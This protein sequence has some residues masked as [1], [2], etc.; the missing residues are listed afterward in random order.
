MPLPGAGLLVGWSRVFADLTPSAS[1][2]SEVSKNSK[3]SN[4]PTTQ[5]QNQK[6][7]S[8]SK[9]KSRSKSKP[10][11]GARAAKVRVKQRRGEGAAKERGLNKSVAK[12]TA[13]ERGLDNAVVPEQQKSAS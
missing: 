7:K 3:H 2:E 6:Q 4:P 5:S 12:T 1:G 10:C 13:K 9:S 8:K 11:E